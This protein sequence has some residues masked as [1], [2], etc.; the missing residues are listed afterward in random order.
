[1]QTL[2]IDNKALAAKEQAYLDLLLEEKSILEKAI[3][4]NKFES[5]LQRIGTQKR[6]W[7]LVNQDIPK[8]EFYIQQFKK[9]IKEEEQYIKEMLPHSQEHMPELIKKAKDLILDLRVSMPDRNAMK[10]LTEAWK[11]EK[12]TEERSIVEAAT[13]LGNFI[14]KYARKLR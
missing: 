12:I 10:E 4:D 13:L 9:R 14:N 8:K 11:D 7:N 2:N 6:L 3:K 1:M 5:G